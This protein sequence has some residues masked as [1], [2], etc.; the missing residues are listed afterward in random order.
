MSILA[1]SEIDTIIIRVSFRILGLQKRFFAGGHVSRQAA[2]CS[3]FCLGTTSE[4]CSAII[5]VR[6]RYRIFSIH[7][8]LEARYVSTSS[9]IAIPLPRPSF[10]RTTVLPGQT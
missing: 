4:D 10:I 6:Q 3:F 2:A 7:T 8:F 9:L 5:S 1:E